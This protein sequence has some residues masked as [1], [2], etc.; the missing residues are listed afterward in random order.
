[1]MFSEK[2]DLC[3][4]GF[5]G[6][7]LPNPLASSSIQPAP[8]LLE[9]RRSNQLHRHGRSPCGMPLQDPWQRSRSLD[10]RPSE[11]RR[12]RSTG[13]DLIEQCTRTSSRSRRR[14]VSNG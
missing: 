8:V 5:T 11:A 2:R 4:K 1:M 3:L 10:V 6:G 13:P 14:H 12:W 9:L 7:S